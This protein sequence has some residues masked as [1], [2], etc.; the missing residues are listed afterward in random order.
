MFL[1]LSNLL[2]YIYVSF[3]FL[4]LLSSNVCFD[5]EERV[6]RSVD[7]IRKGSGCTISMATDK[8]SWKHT[9]DDSNNKNAKDTYI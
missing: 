3:A 1:A 9:L 6:A 5:K 2:F 7:K 4:L 8:I